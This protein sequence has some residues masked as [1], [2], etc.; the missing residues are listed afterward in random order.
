MASRTLA[1]P[2]VN[3]QFVQALIGA[4]M[5]YVR[6]SILIRVTGAV[7][8]SYAFVMLPSAGA[9]PSVEAVEKAIAEQTNAYRQREQLKPLARDN[10]LHETAR[11][12][13][14]YMAETA[15]FGHKV[16]GRTPAQRV[17]Q[18]GYEH[19]IVRE[20]IGFLELASDTSAETIADRLLSGW[21]ASDG[22]RRNL[23]AANVTGLGIGV[24][25]SDSEGNPK[26]QRRYYAVQLFA[27]PLA[28]A[29]RFSVRNGRAQTINYTVD[30]KNFALPPNTV[31]KHLRCSKPLIEATVR[32]EARTFRPGSG[33]TV[34]IQ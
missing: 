9:S 15:Q 27:R 10:R 5:R 3:T 30:G 28:D 34:E 18:A 20:N 4:I 17:R 2:A 16:D 13:A 11:R 1:V 23:K 24:S 29:F 7:G 25:G 22:H 8:F 12:F 26:G 33:E 14:N 32:G 19:C 6:T 21:I 31:H